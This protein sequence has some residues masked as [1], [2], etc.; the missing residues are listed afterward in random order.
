MIVLG[1]PAELSHILISWL[2]DFYYWM[3]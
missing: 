1:V 3:G 2:R